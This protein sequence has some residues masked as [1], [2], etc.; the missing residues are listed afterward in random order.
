MVIS[1]LKLILYRKDG[2]ILNWLPAKEDLKLQNEIIPL[3]LLIQN[4]LVTIS[5]VVDEMNIYIQYAFHEDL[6]NEINLRLEEMFKLSN[7]EKITENSNKQNLTCVK[8]DKSWYRTRI[9]TRQRNNY[10]VCYN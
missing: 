8:L 9:I 2:E 1:R 7:L 10:K 6:K 4:A 5:H 3:P